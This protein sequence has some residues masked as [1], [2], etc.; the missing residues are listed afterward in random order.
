M[1]YLI[2]I[3]T[4]ISIVLL[5]VSYT[6]D[7]KKVKHSRALKIFTLV[8]VIVT[9]IF[10]SF[11]SIKTHLERP[12]S[13]DEVI[14]QARDVLSKEYPDKVYN[15]SNIS[16]KEEFTKKSAIDTLTTL[17]NKVV[18][19]E[20]KTSMK[21]RYDAIVNDKTSYTNNISEE[22]I[23][24]LYQVD[25]FNTEDMKANMSLALLSITNSVLGENKEISVK[26]SNIENVYLSKETNTVKIPLDIYTN[27]YSGYTI[28]MV[29]INGHWY[30]DSYSLMNQVDII[31]YLQK[32]YNKNNE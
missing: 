4:F 14:E 8:I 24:R 10:T 32:I 26:A 7:N 18:D 17:L 28:D 1:I 25:N 20:N 21:D 30:I 19:K 23:N 5:L 13:P 9:M 2:G 27:H 3:V 11:Y 6:L 15:A 29:F 12:V 22:V 31:S 16:D